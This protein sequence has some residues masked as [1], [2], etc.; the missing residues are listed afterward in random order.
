MDRGNS[1][2]QPTESVRIRCPR[3]RIELDMLPREQGIT[4]P[5]TFTLI[6]DQRRETTSLTQFPKNSTLEVILELFRTSLRRLHPHL[7]QREPYG[8]VNETTGVLSKSD[9]VRILAALQRIELEKE[10]LYQF[11]EHTVHR[12]CHI[13]RLVRVRER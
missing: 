6:A 3:C 5:Q 4:F 12:Y 10:R 2:N 8:P 7:F 1:K 9:E 13:W 11:Q